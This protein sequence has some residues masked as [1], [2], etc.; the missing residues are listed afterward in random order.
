MSV[1]L[2][3]G[4]KV[5]L[6]KDNDG[7]DKV[8]I[9]LGWDAAERKK[10]G[11][12]SAKPKPID[13]DASVIALQGGKLLENKDIIYF[14]NLKHHS[15]SIIHTGDNLTGD[16]DGDDE[17]VI[18]ELSKIPENYD[19]IVFIVNIYEATK[20]NQHFGMINNAYIRIIDSRTNTEM[21]KYNLT[22]DYSNMTSMI[23]GEIY[24]HNDEWKF[25]PIGQGTTD[26]GLPA[27]AKKFV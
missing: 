3:K 2:K 12:F 8:I 1:S 21:F 18:V 20:R 10:S 11:L 7:L 25:N 15:G 6:T 9:G 23:F 16:G 13:C 17:Q 26:D 14:G 24:R 5:S 22:D 4:Q 27:V 19:K